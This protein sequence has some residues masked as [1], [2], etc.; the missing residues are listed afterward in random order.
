TEF[1]RRLDGLNEAIE[2][3][4]KFIARPGKPGY[5]VVALSHL[6]M[7]PEM[8][9]SMDEAARLQL[10]ADWTLA[11]KV[12]LSHRKL[13]CRTFRT[14]R[15][16]GVFGLAYH[17]AECFVAEHPVVSALLGLV[18]AVAAGCTLLK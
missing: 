17:A 10:A 16:Q 12:L 9:N 1:K 2:D 4:P 5:R 14:L 7:T 18:V 3:F 13:L 8:F 15:S 11:H 6:D